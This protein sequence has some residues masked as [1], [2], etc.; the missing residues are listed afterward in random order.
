MLFFPVGLN[1]H[2]LNFKSNFFIESNQRES[3]THLRESLS[4]EKR[5]DRDGAASNPVGGDHGRC[6]RACGQWNHKHIHEA[7]HYCY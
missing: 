1:T 2:I 3:D 4:F 6:S 7:K 5:G